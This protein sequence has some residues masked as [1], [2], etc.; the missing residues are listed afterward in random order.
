MEIKNIFKIVKSLFVDSNPKDQPA[1]TYT[2]A[3]NTV[4]ENDQG[5]NTTRSNEESNAP[6][7]NITPGY[8]PIGKVYMTGN[9]ICIFSVSADGNFSEI[10]IFNTD[11]DSYTVYVN[12]MSSTLKNRLNFRVDRQIDA[13]YRLVLGCQDT[14]YWVDNHNKPRQFNFTKLENYQDQNG[15]WV[16]SKFNLQ[17]TYDKIP[18]FD[19]VEVL[20]SGGNIPPGSLNFSIQ[21]VDESFSSTE[22]IVDSPTVKIYNDLSSKPYAEINGSIN[23]DMEHLAFPNTNKAVRLEFSNLDT[24]YLYYRIAI[25]CSNNGTGNVNAVYYSEVIPTSKRFYIYTGTNH[26][27]EGTEEEILQFSNIIHK[28]EHIEQIENRLLLANTQGPQIDFCKLQKFASKIKVDCIVKDIVLNDINDEKNS[29]NAV[30]EFK[31]GIGYMP[32]EIYSIGIVYI[33]EDN[34]LSPVFHIPGK[35]EEHSNVVFSP[36]TDGQVN[37]ITFPMSANNKCEDTTYISNN[38]CSSGGSWGLDYAGEPL[39]GKNVR[40]HR[41]PLRSEI[42][43]P[44]IQNSFAPSQESF[45]YNLILKVEGD[46]KIPVP[47]PEDNPTCGTDQYYTFEIRVSYKVDGE[48]FTFTEIIDPSYYQD[49]EETV[50]DLEFFA[51]SNNHNSN[52]ITDIVIEITDLNGDFQPID[53]FDFSDY[54]E[55]TPNIFTEISENSSLINNKKVT[56]KILGLKLSNIEAIPEEIVGKKIVGFYIVRNERTEFEKTILDNG[57]LVPNIN[58]AKY[59]S[60]GLLFPQGVNRSSITTGIIHPE[61]KFNGKEYTNY[62]NIICQGYFKAFNFKLGKI[63]YDDVQAGSS[64]TDKMNKKMDDGEDPDGSPTSR[65]LDGWSFNLITRDVI[66]D[67]FTSNVSNSFNLGTQ[68]LKESFYLEALESRSIREGAFDVYNL[69]T[70]NKI[71]IIEY[72]NT[73]NYKDFPYVAM[74]K[75]NS[76]PYSNFRLLPYYKETVN[77]IYF[78]NSVS[79]EVAIFNGDTYICPMRYNNTMFYDNRIAKRKMKVPAW[80]IIVGALI[81]IAAVVVSV[82]SFGTAT[83]LAAGLSA[84]AITALVGTGIAVAGVGAMLLSSGIKQANYNKAYY[85]EYDKGLRNT[86]LDLFTHMFYHYT[87]IPFGFSGNGGAG[88]DGPSDD[89][90]C[91]VSDCV[92]DFWFESSVNINL[93]NRFSNSENPTFLYSPW[94]T[95]TGNRSKIQTI[96][97]KGMK[98][99]DSNAQRYPVSSLERHGVKKLLAFDASRDDS[100]IYLGLALGEYY[101]VN[102]DYARRAKQKIYTH[103]PLEYDCCSDCKEK[104]PHRIHYS[105]Q[106][107]QE[108]LTDNY[109]VFLPN[110]YVDIDGSTGEITNMFK[111]GNELFIHTEE[112]LWQ[113][114]RN[115]QERITDQIVSFIGTGSYFSIPPR[116]VVDG[117]TGNSAGTRHKWGM[118]KTPQGVFFPSEIQNKIYKF[119]GKS[120]LPISD[121]GLK[122]WFKNNTKILQDS[123][124]FN[125]TGKKYPYS[126]NPS[127]PNGT[128]YIST[129]DSRKDRVIFTKKDEIYIERDLNADTE[130]CMKG[131]KMIVFENF[132]DIISEKESEGW[133]YV[134]ME[135]C[136]LKFERERYETVTEPW[137][138][139]DPHK[140]KNDTDIVIQFDTS[141]SFTNTARENLQNTIFGWFTSFKIAN[142]DYSGRLFF[143]I[144]RGSCDSQAWLK[145]L[146]TISEAEPGN[147]ELF[148][149]DTDINSVDYGQLDNK[150]FT[151]INKNFIIISTVHEATI[152]GCYGTGEYHTLDTQHGLID[153]PSSEYLTDFNEFRLLYDDLVSQD[154]NMNFLLYPV[155]FS[156]THQ[157]EFAGMFQHFISAIDGANTISQ[158]VKDKLI[159]ES[160][161]YLSPYHYSNIIYNFT[162]PNPYPIYSDGKSLRDLH[163][164]YIHTVGWDG[165]SAEVVSTSKFTSDIEGYL[166][167]IGASTTY[168]TIEVDSLISYTEYTFVDGEEFTPGKINNS[169]TLSYDILENGWISWHSYL[170]SMYFNVAENFYSWINSSDIIWKHNVLANYQNFF[171]KRYPFIIEFV[172]NENPSFNKIFDSIEFITDAMKYD[173]DSEEFV[174]EKYLTFNKAIFYNSRQTTGILNLVVKDTNNDPEDY[175]YQQ[176]DN[177]DGD[178]VIID[179]NWLNWSINRIRDM[180]IDYSKPIFKKGL[181]DRQ[182]DYFIDKV[183][184]I[185]TVDYDKTWDE[186]QPLRDKYLQVRLIFDNFDDIKLIF[187]FA[188]ETDV[189]SI[190]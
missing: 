75:K 72:E 26:V 39:E 92:T 173:F 45:Y 171:G 126:N 96:K 188:T 30:H 141:P 167:S 117:E 14:I 190:R 113:M 91:W 9:R 155:I 8:I 99:T 149:V 120:L 27:S 29:K 65:G 77:P 180:R 3:L 177:F 119:D 163:W 175:L 166:L 34:T 160:N 62:D 145:S 108:E 81:V 21:Y 25:I 22:W 73:F 63:N 128:G 176:I 131:D 116:L 33:F 1:G 85:E 164:N 168:E 88:E 49:G 68:D 76:N 181:E 56:S 51:S 101:H 12:D 23:S 13:R 118:I 37:N 115:Y 144:D 28:A 53:T 79:T 59:I 7:V 64:F 78:N 125:F 102:P 61:F 5:E 20:D 135:N 165:A 146:K 134:G 46:L 157:Q 178:T 184:D 152:G 90:I 158:E 71:G 104:F 19:S 136:R 170:P 97:I 100:K 159:A 57:V 4:K 55:T 140:L 138:V 82:F 95:E 127:N 89:T 106:S 189:P 98:Y 93:R 32:G 31:N 52:N 105:E 151:D 121:F 110:N 174:D 54:F 83:P 148:L 50:F 41:F 142:P 38:T 69:A 60:N 182:Q 2:F 109:R 132:Q 74:Y 87:Q 183:L 161:I 122:S 18:H 111:I 86:I 112:A 169:W 42:G 43:L 84:A 11:D 130:I 80:K 186:Q 103:L 187:N 36:Q 66:V 70:D 24:N 162:V 153:P 44:L 172:C 114:P 35:R 107:F 156:H 48:D 179:K 137:E 185:T 47:C 123:S 16:A 154:Y 139:Q 40:H 150:V 15:N 143:Y 67:Y 129:Y 10:G 124:Y 133:Y 58:N 6:I 17:K 147:K 94:R